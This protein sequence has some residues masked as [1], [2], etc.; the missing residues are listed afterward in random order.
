[1]DIQ[2]QYPVADPGE[3]SPPHPPLLFL[4][5]TEAEGPNFFLNRLNSPAPSPI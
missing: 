2:T 1:M 5:Q 3:P 4:V